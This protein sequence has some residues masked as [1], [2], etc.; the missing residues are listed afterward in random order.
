MRDAYSYPPRGLS[1]E[2][3]ARCAADKSCILGVRFMR[4]RQVGISHSK[5]PA[6]IEFALTARGLYFRF[7]FAP[8]TVVLIL[9]LARVCQRL[10]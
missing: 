10:L 2:E 6:M 5:E 7:Q 4:F 1:R 8:E 3:A 9:I